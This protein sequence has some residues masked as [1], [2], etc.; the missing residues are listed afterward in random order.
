MAA[1][2]V[3]SVLASLLPSLCPVCSL[4]CCH[5]CAQCARFVALL[6]G[7]V[8]SPPCFHLCAQCARP[9]A[10]ISVLS[11]H[12]ARQPVQIDKS[13]DAL[14]ADCW[15]ISGLRSKETLTVFG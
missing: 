11:V 5:L 6:L 8:C 15:E 1:I 10:S 3:R 14:F 7:A 9:L 12:R 4:R 2:S 13:A